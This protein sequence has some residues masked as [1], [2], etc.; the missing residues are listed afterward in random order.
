[1]PAAKY[2]TSDGATVRRVRATILLHPDLH[3]R[4]KRHAYRTGV[5]LSDWVAA[6]V[7]D[8]LKWKLPK[9]K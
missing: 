1:M 9:E 5:G 8:T 4:A 3:L 6:L 2:T 7:A